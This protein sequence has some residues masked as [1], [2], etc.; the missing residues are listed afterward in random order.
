MTLLVLTPDDETTAAVD[1]TDGLRALRYDPHDPSPPPG[2]EEAEALI[3]SSAAVSTI[4]ELAPQLPKL[5]IA[6]TLSAGFDA[7]DGKLPAGVALSNCRGA[8]GRATAELA[9]TML[10]TILREIREFIEDQDGRDW[11]DRTTDSLFGKRVLILGAGDLAEHARAMLAPFGATATLV[12]RTARDGVI[13]LADVPALLPSTDAV[14]CVL[15]E[16]PETHHTIDAAFLAA[17]PDDAIVVNVARGGL[18]DTAALLAELEARRLRAGLD[19]TDPEPLPEDH[20][21]WTAPGLLLTPHVGGST[22]GFPERAAA[23]A[24]EQLRQF[25]AGDRPDNLVRE[26]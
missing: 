4:L 11:A 6:Q 13:T 10:L 14:I 26:G 12:G 8:H 20:P 17:L 18:V 19:V 2:A 5:R 1:A 23:V 9:V 21:L 3:T 25:A 24:A 22:L 15:P 16:S 7:W